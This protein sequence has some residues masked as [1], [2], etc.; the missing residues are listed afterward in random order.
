MRPLLKHVTEIQ[1]AHPAHA[2]RIC[3][4]L[5]NG[6]DVIEQQL[7]RGGFGITYVARNSLDR[8]VVIKECFPSE[9]CKRV[10]G[11]VCAAAPDYEDRLAAIK[12]QFVR[13]ARRMA[14]LQHQHQH[15][16]I[17]AVHKVFEEN[18]ST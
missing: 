2:L 14:K 5:L 3:V 6:Q 18:I 11:L 10:D 1:D 16:H 9:M 17:V 7:Q 8:L 4:R 15:Q 13:E 12:R